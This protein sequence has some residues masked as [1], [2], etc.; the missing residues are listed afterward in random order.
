MYVIKWWNLWF[1][2]SVFS[3]CLI[4]WV[5]VCECVVH[6]SIHICMCVSRIV[7]IMLLP[8]RK[9]DYVLH[10][11]IIT[12]ILSLPTVYGEFCLLSLAKSQLFTHVNHGNRFCRIGAGAS[13]PTVS[14]M[15]F[16][17]AFFKHHSLEN[18]FY[19]YYLK[20]GIFLILFSA[21]ILKYFLN[22]SI[23]HCS[24]CVFHRSVVKVSIKVSYFSLSHTYLHTYCFN[25][26]FLL[27]FC[28]IF[29]YFCQQFSSFSW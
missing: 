4:L 12:L 22:I 29:N 18:L 26:S 21:L 19:F 1:Y 15:L 28:F 17:T 11:I 16:K 20:T 3:E 23:L 5:S 7:S 25:R 2:A 10:A 9:L 14:F 6:I 24:L 8:R 13:R 27:L